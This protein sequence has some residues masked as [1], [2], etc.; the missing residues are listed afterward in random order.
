M[1]RLVDRICSLLRD[2]SGRKDNTE[3]QRV[4][5][6]FKTR[7]WTF[8]QLLEL[9]QRSL[10]TIAEMEQQ[11][12]S[13]EP[14]GMSFV[15]ARATSLSVC[16]YQIVEKLDGLAPGKYTRLNEAL[17]A[18][19]ER[20]DT[21]LASHFLPSTGPLV[22]R[23][24]ATGKEDVD[25]VG[26]KMAMLGEITGGPQLS[27]PDGFTVTAAGYDLF[28]GHQGLRE[29]ISQH[30]QAAP[31]DDL[32]MLYDVC[33][34]IQDE[35]LNA[36]LPPELEQALDQALE[37]F[38]QAHG[39]EALLAVRSSALGEDGPRLSF[40]G[41]Y[42]SILNVPLSEVAR[43]YRQVV[44]G[45]YSAR[46]LAYRH[47]HGLRDKDIRMCVGCMR[48]VDPVLSGVV[49]SRDPGNPRQD[50]VHINA[51]P[52][53]GSQVVD[54]S[55][56]PQTYVLSREED[57]WRMVSV[58]SSSSDAE[59]VS[60]QPD[61]MLDFTQSAEL[62][63][64]SRILEAH[65][66][67]AQDV[68]WALDHQGRILLLQ[69]RSLRLGVQNETGAAADSDRHDGH[70]PKPL[71][72]AG[73]CASSGVA[74]GPVRVLA[75]REDGAEV[76][77]GEIVVVESALPDWA[78]LLPRCGAVVA[79]RGGAAS[80]LATVAREYDVPALFN[81]LRATEVLASGQEVTVD[82]DGCRVYPGRVEELLAT[83]SSPPEPGSAR[84]SERMQDSP[85]AA[86]LR[87]VLKQVTPLNLVSPDKPEFLPEYCQTYHDIIRFCHEQAVVEMFAFGQES[88]FQ[89]QVGRRLVTS[90]PMQ[91]W[92]V[93]LAQD[94]PLE[95]GQD[96]IPLSA[97]SSTP[98]LAI[99]EGI[100]AV[101]WA[102]PPSPDMRGFFSVMANSA[103][104]TDLDVCAQS[105]MR[106][107]NCAFVSPRFCS[108]NCRFGY[109]FTVIQAYVGERARENY[110]RFSFQGGAT[111]HTRKVRRLELIRNVL[112]EAR[113]LLEIRGDVLTAR[114]E[115]HD[116]EYLR[117]RLHAL[118][119][120]IMHTRQIDM[121]M[122]DEGK[123]RECLNMLRTHVQTMTEG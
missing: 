31:L 53:L 112:E 76:Q 15:R 23:L 43:A 44:A 123:R 52:G 22:I 119:F 66:G 89:G 84:G 18:V 13:G 58:G 61:R 45:K 100:E 122:N 12:A 29:R 32:E 105:V 30:L 20:I 16:V 60:P 101:P 72:H 121:V 9:N 63:E 25:Q 8:K 46:A 115:G 50:R 80:H 75:R 4:R 10:E 104:N 70:W 114:I 77:P 49:Y 111:D 2:S 64:Y 48:M 87:R 85:V 91:W 28:M 69:S 51:A 11:L 99:W 36:A 42:S 21:E 113:F 38:Q 95:P 40:A 73:V 39:P 93:D 27:V 81:T 41:Q 107:K 71:L 116:P 33:E 55:V 37:E 56:S 86:V 62:A 6:L 97:I 3:A 106:Q 5:D 109:H 98:F 17:A 67:S 120:L 96:T 47:S 54:G 88:G 7:Y 103:M 35:I 14:F 65:F 59:P 57:A 74:S 34:D 26:G 102:G 92:I 118:G 79:D 117:K 94:A 78:V 83:R 19:R 110:I 68:E 24:D 90:V 1:V 82:A 108:L